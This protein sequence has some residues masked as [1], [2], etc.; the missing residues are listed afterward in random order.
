MKGFLYSEIKEG[1]MS[2]LRYQSMF[3]SLERTRVTEF[4]WDV[5]QGFWGTDGKD[6]GVMEGDGSTGDIYVMY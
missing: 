6:S 4:L 3:F 5:E 1:E 2:G